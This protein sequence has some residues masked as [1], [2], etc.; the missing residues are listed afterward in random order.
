MVFGN[1]VSHLLMTEEYNLKTFVPIVLN[2]PGR[3]STERDNQEILVGGDLANARTELDELYQDQN[4][5]L[6]ILKT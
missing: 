1:D 6:Q 5:I 2:F 3:P 4:S